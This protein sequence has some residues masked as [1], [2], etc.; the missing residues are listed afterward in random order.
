MTC[1]EAGC[2]FVCTNQGRA[3][4]SVGV[5]EKAKKERKGNICRKLAQASHEQHLI[6]DDSEDKLLT[7]KI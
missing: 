4:V 2:E 1:W 6:S 5:N 7:F 3:W